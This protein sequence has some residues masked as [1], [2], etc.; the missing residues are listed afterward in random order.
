MNSYATIS[1]L[2]SRSLPLKLNIIPSLFGSFDPKPIYLRTDPITER[3]VATP[4][5]LDQVRSFI[6]M[7]HEY[8]V[9]RTDTTNLFKSK[10]QHGLM[11]PLVVTKTQNDPNEN[12]SQLDFFSNSAFERFNRSF[13]K[14][15]MLFQRY[16]PC[17]GAN[18][19]VVRCVYHRDR[20]QKS[21]Y[22]IQNTVKMSGI[23]ETYEDTGS[24]K[25]DRSHSPQKRH[26]AQSESFLMTRDKVFSYA[27]DI[28]KQIKERLEQ[29]DDPNASPLEFGIEQILLSPTVQASFDMYGQATGTSQKSNE[30]YMAQVALQEEIDKNCKTIVQYCTQDSKLEDMT[31]VEAKITNYPSI[32]EQM[33]SLVAALDS[34]LRTDKHLQLKELVVDFVTDY[35]DDRNY[36][37]QIKFL[38]A[39]TFVKHH[40]L[41]PMFHQRKV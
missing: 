31:V 20:M 34:Y 4:L 13:G 1:N 30:L 32:N 8:N 11:I 3:V 10:N 2:A 23:V 18:A 41:K 19:N 24:P 26:Q 12:V 22:R 28:I 9:G 39:E 7:V 27:N 14:S 33:N 25:R 29:L 38:D 35:L 16:V 17:K 40:A 15:Y 37:L 5:P 6:D 21:V 36:F